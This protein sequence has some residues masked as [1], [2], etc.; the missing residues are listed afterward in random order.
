[1]KFFPLVF[2]F[3]VTVLLVTRT[4]FLF[5]I[6]TIVLQNFW[7]K[8]AGKFGNKFYWRDEGP[9]RAI[10]NSVNAIDFCL[11]EPESRFK[12]TQL[13]SLEEEF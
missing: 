9:D 5:L 3:K 12:C 8:V 6:Q 2:I 1:M 10:I 4:H 7:S 13:N 11:R